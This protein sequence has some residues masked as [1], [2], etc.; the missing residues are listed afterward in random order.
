MA[1][2]RQSQKECSFMAKCF[3]GTNVSISLLNHY[4]ETVVSIASTS[5][6]TAK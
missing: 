2:L 4:P 5:L 3:C 1:L 6:S